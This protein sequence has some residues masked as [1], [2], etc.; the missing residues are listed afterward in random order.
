MGLDSV[1]QAPKKIDVTIGIA[2]RNN[3]ALLY[4]C[5]KSVHDCAR[6]ATFEI[7]VVDNASTDGS[8]ESVASEFPGIRVIRNESPR[9][10]GASNNQ[11]FAASSGRYF[12]VL[13]NDTLFTPGVLESLVGHMESGSSMGCVG[14]RI[15]NP[16]GSLQHSCSRT[17]TFL[18]QLFQDLAPSKLLLP[19]NTLRSR[20]YEWDHNEDRDVPVISGAFMLFRRDAFERIGGFDENFEFYLEEFDICERVRA[21]GYR[22]V[23]TPRTSITHLGGQSMRAAPIRNYIILRQSREKYVRKHLGRAQA[24]ELRATA[25]AGTFVRLAGWTALWLTAPKDRERARAMINTYSSVLPKL[26]PFSK[27]WDVPMTT[28]SR[29]I[30]R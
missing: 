27:T 15:L 28:A 6:G 14:C 23:F 5:V 13:N 16:D 2:H 3:R 26:F 21:A 18:N 25:F 10:Y 17:I 22:V 24:L 19:R 7:I 1:E 9:G 11:A 12:L 8:A 4:N 30:V 20:M 29:M